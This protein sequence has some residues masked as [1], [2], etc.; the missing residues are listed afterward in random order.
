MTTPSETLHANCVGFQGR[1]VLILGP[2]NAGKS[3]LSLQLMA[4]GAGLV[5]DDRTIVSLRGADLWAEC[6]VPI[7]GLI[8]AR[9]LGILAAD[10]HPAVKLYFAV[11]LGQ[12]EEARLPLQRHFSVLG[13]VL[14]L[15]HG[16]KGADF[17][18]ALLQLLRSGWA[19]GG[20]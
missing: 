1:G 4:L 3:A 14:P 18:S 20:R 7:R 19:D 15:V 10:A 17:P 6:P 9:G 11:D 2:A 12:V 5:A 13:G 16:Q 8:E